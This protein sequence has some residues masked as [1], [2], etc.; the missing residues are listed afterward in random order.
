MLGKVTKRDPIRLKFD[1]SSDN[2]AC[3]IQKRSKLAVDNDG[4]DRGSRSTR[5]RIKS[6]REKAC[7]F[8]HEDF[9]ESILVN[10]FTEE[11]A[12]TEDIKKLVNNLETYSD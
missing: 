2:L 10:T 5:K 3:F 9:L 7:I 12:C 1:T 6:N 4:N 11:F 8:R